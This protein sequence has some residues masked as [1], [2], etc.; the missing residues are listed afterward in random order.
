MFFF[1]LRILITP[2]VS[3]NSSPNNHIIFTLDVIQSLFSMRINMCSSWY[4]G[5]NCREDGWLG[6]ISKVQ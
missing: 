4:E 2:L 6:V 1:D 5:D 3:S